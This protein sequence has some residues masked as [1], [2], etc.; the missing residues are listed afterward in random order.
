MHATKGS[1]FAGL[2]SDTHQIKTAG[3]YRLEIASSVLFGSGLVIT[4]SQSGSATHSYTS[5]TTSPRELVVNFNA[6]FSCAV[7]DIL[8]VTLSSSA[9]IDQPPNKIQ[10]TIILKQIG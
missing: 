2:G 6:L 5:N 4:L 1:V 9:T 7:G 8:T 3:S 10:T